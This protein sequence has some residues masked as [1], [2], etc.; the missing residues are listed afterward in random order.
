MGKTN[1][2]DKDYKPYH[3]KEGD[4]KLKN[5]KNYLV[6]LMGINDNYILKKVCFPDRQGENFGIVTDFTKICADKVEFIYLIS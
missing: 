1:A 3:V 6:L 4:E 5:W 2:R